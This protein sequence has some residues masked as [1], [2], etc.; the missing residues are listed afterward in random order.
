MYAYICICISLALSFKRTKPKIFKFTIW[1]YASVRPRVLKKRHTAYTFSYPFPKKSFCVFSF[2]Y[3]FSKK[4][5]KLAFSYL[6]NEHA[7]P[8]SVF[9]K[10]LVRPYL[11]FDRSTLPSLLRSFGFIIGREAQVEV[12]FGQKSRSKIG[13]SKYRKGRTDA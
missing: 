4:K 12:Q 13:G 9:F 6:E 2:S 11:Y 5:M 8:G 10:T 3:P 1:W 7:S